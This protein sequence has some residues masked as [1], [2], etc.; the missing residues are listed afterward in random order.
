MTAAKQNSPTAAEV[1]AGLGHPIVDGDGH[2]VEYHPVMMEALHDIGGDL[3]ADGYARFGQTIG[4][5]VSLTTEERRARNMGHEA[6]WSVPTA[7]TLDRATSMMPSLLNE[8]L[9]EFGIDFTVLYPTQGLGIVTVADEDM[10]IAACRAYNSF[11]A[12]YFAPHADRMTPAAVIPMF[13]PEEAV[14]ELDHAVGELGMKAT[15]FGSMIPRPVPALVERD[16]D[17]ADEVVWLDV[18]GLDSPYDYDLVWQRCGDLGVSPSFH[19]NGRGRGFGLRAS[20][21]NFVYNHIGHFAAAD[22]AVC[23]ALLLGG[24]THR[25]PALQFAFL[26]GGVGWACQLLND[27]IEHWEVRNPDALHRINPKNLDY[28]LLDELAREHGSDAMQRA[29]ARRLDRPTNPAEGLLAGRLA[30]DD[31]GACEIVEASDFLDLFVKPFFFGCEAEDRLAAWAFK[32]E[33]NAFGAKLNATFGS[34]I[35]HFDVADMSKV[36]VDAHELVDDGL[37]SDNDFREFAFANT[38]RFFGGQNPAFFNGTRVEQAA[39][40]ELALTD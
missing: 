20:P 8:R 4:S 28:A 12:E 34:D 21:S 29:V 7:N 11:A 9:D 22:E 15:M 3:A 13:T 38:T 31:F 5:N 1:R 17:A 25:F 40:Q 23:K 14:E 2:W 37:M 6:W 30:P 36:L 33:H 19:A 18:L 39:R 35:G 32:T 10:R 16:S 26:E 24:V 27:L